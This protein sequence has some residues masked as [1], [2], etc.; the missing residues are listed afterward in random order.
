MSTLITV[1]GFGLAT[2]GVWVNWGMGYALLTGGLVLFLAGGL[3]S[4]RE[5]RNRGAR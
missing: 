3:E 2:A 1:I 5:G 4:V